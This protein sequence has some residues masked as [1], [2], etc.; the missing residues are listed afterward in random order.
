M[1]SLNILSSSVPGDSE[2]LLPP[3]PIAAV[4]GGDVAAAVDAIRAG[5]WRRRRQLLL[6]LQRPLVVDG[7]DGGGGDQVQRRN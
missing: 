4:V 3:I 2:L 6:L 5:N 1:R 7:D